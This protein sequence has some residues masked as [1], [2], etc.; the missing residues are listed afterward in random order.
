V[1]LKEA[2]KLFRMCYPAF[3]RDTEVHKTTPA[4]DHGPDPRACF[5]ST[6]S[7]EWTSLA[8]SGYWIVAG[9]GS[10]ESQGT[11]PKLGWNAGEEASEAYEQ[12]HYL[13]G[14]RNLTAWHPQLTEN[15]GSAV[16]SLALDK[17]WPVHP[18]GVPHGAFPSRVLVAAKFSGSQS[19]QSVRRLRAGPDPLPCRSRFPGGSSD[20]G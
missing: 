19:V 20:S 4:Q 13:S 9:I 18:C 17:F 15:G 11:W 5:Q 2:W 14:T 12:H 1:C 7:F 6:R 3:H 10:H 8:A 16:S